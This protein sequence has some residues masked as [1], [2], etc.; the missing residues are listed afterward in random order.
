LINKVA[1]PPGAHLRARDR[2][3]AVNER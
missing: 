2:D 1:V 3:S